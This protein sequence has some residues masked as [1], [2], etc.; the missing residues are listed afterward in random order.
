MIA[1]YICVQEGSG[2]PIQI[3][4]CFENIN[5]AIQALDALE[6]FTPHQYWIGQVP[7]RS[8]RYEAEPI[9]Y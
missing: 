5:D 9:L 2:E 6:G 7:S 4:D 3:I 1:Y 8:V